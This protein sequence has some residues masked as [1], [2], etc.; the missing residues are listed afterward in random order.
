MVNESVIDNRG[1]V[2]RVMGVNKLHALQGRVKKGGF[3]LFVE[4]V[5]RKFRFGALR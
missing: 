5:I 4:P 1:C 2:L 3:R